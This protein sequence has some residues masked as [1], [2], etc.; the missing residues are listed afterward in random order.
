M[1]TPL[2]FT[3]D[4]R[5]IQYLVESLDII[6]RNCNSYHQGSRPDYRV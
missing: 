4:N 3:P 2:I 6:E 1:D 5:D